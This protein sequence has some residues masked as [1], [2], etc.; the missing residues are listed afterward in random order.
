MV[1]AAA[2]FLSPLSADAAPPRRQ[3]DPAAM[4]VVTRPDP[5]A[6][7]GDGSYD[8]R[9]ERSRRYR[10]PRFATKSL[11]SL[12]AG[13]GTRKATSEFSPSSGVDGGHFRATSPFLVSS[14]RDATLLLVNWA[15]ATLIGTMV[16]GVFVLAHEPGRLAKLLPAAET[17]ALGKGTS[18]IQVTV[19]MH[20]PQRHDSTS[21][22]SV[23]RRMASTAKT[24]SREG[25]QELVSAVAM[26]LL[27]RKSS[28]VSAHAASKHFKKRDH[29]LR[30]YGFWSARERSNFEQETITNYGGK[31][32]AAAWVSEEDGPRPRLEAKGGESKRTTTTTTLAV[33]T[34]LLAIDGDVTRPRPIRSL[35]S[36]EDA[37]GRITVDAPTDACLR[38]AEI[39][40][41]P[42]E[43]S[44]T[45]TTVDVVVDYPQLRPV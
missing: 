32:R 34:L 30:E 42:S 12:C 28:I 7:L 18:V 40:W 39:L 13:P 21:I 23:L 36:V 31:K 16:T 10:S 17:S 43:P 33:V 22:L 6:L 35:A 8:V 38:S 45:L 20:V 25:V 11:P 37:L 29:A 1:L 44:E 41:T 5:S 15:L 27:R 4:H 14:A 19:A 9:A 2:L 3:Y 26:E 24:D